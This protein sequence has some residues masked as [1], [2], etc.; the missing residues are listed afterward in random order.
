MS[1]GQSKL[2]TSVSLHVPVSHL[3]HSLEA[4]VYWLFLLLPL[5]LAAG[6]CA[7]AMQPQ[8]TF[9]ALPK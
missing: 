2:S 6:V 1:L 4:N 8:N 9:Y 7:A 3:S 5:L